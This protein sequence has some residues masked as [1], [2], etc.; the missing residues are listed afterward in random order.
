MESLYKKKLKKNLNKILYGIIMKKMQV[1]II[2]LLLGSIN[3]SAQT[4]GI[5]MDISGNA[6]EKTMG[7]GSVSIL[8]NING[9][10]NNPA[11]IA[12]IDFLNGSFTYINYLEDF[13]LF[14]CNILYP[15]VKNFNIF[16][17][18]G[19]FYMPPETDIITGNELEYKELFFGLGTGYH[20]LDNKLSVGATANFY[21]SHIAGESASTVYINMGTCYPIRLP[22]VEYH[23]I[24]AGLSILNLGPG[25]KYKE[26]SSPL[27]INMNLGIQ[28]IYLYDYKLFAGIRKYTAYDN[29]LASLGVEAIIA[30]ALFVRGSMEQDVK[31][32]LKYNIG[33]GFDLNYAGNHF[34]LDYAFMPL[35]ASSPTSVIS[36]TFK[37]PLSTTKRGDP[38]KDEKNWK[39]MWTRE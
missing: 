11:V 20:F 21:N 2:L 30:N 22:I 29:F 35:E 16:G 17:N 34:L 26:E 28:Y 25:L 23:V 14:N 1:I 33:I 5:A 36:F 6:Y 4:S 3:V 12:N 24:I 19:Y 32:N 7:F 9:V 18:L 39:N 27:P 8:N 13:K 38:E 10:F 31:K 37:I 15:N